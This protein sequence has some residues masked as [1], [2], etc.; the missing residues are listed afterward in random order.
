MTVH[1]EQIRSRLDDYLDGALA[2]EEAGEIRAHLADCPACEEQV[3]RARQLQLRLRNLPAPQ[4]EDGFADRQFRQL[5]E[6][7][8]QSGRGRGFS[9]LFRDPALAAALLLGLF[10]GGAVTQWFG[11]GSPEPGSPVRVVTLE[12]NEAREVRF[13]ITANRDMDNVRLTLDLPENTELV[14][15]PGQRQVSWE[16]RL[17][18]GVNML[19]VPVRAAQGGEGTLTMRLSTESGYQQERT[20]RLRS[21]AVETSLKWM[22]GSDHEAGSPI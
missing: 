11:T 15:F 21:Q 9:R 19:R 10:L 2:A 14:G 3:R 7:E 16:T 5:W 22:P 18:S 12:A 20:L 17:D 13:A 4:P 1:C 8:A 6:R